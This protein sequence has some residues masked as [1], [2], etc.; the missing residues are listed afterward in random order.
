MGASALTLS[1]YLKVICGILIVCYTSSMSELDRII[2]A[3][4]DDDVNVA[5][6]ALLPARYDQNEK[7]I[8]SKEGCPKLLHSRGLC[9]SHYRTALRLT[10]NGGRKVP[11]PAPDPAKVRS[12]HNPNN[13]NRLRDTEMLRK[14]NLKTAYGLSLEDYEDMLKSQGHKCLICGFD[15][16][17]QEKNP[18]VDHDHVTGQ[19]RGILCHY[20]N[21][22]LGHAKDNVSTLQNAITYLQKFTQTTSAE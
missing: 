19:V 18:H 1:F 6:A 22:M 17:T 9:Q 5:Q 2:T 20:C 3:P 12:R 15:F 14:H 4:T 8:C 10:R 11:G 21:L 13:P 16:T 7:Q